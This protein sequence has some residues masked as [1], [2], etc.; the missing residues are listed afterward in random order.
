MKQK[1]LIVDDKPG[2]LLALEK[3]LEALDAVIVR[4]GSGE[5]AL[6]ACL[7]DEF[8]LAILDVQMPGMDG[9]ELARYLRGDSH[10][11]MLPIIFLSAVFSDEA[12]V[13][14]GY[15][16]G[17]VDFLTK[18]FRAEHLLGKARFFLEFDRQRAEL[19]ESKKALED[20]LKAQRE[21]SE[22]LAR[23]I[24]ARR[25]AQ[26]E[27]QLA[28]EAAEAANQAKGIFLA[29]MSHELRTPMNG[30]VGMLQLLASAGL[31]P[32][33]REYVDIAKSSALSLLRILSDI[34]DLS[35]IEAGK[36]E[37]REEPF[38]P[39]ELVSGVAQ[40]LHVEARGKGLALS[41]R[42]EAALPGCVSGDS[43][44]V[45]QVLINLAG[46]AIKFTTSGSVLIEAGYQESPGGKGTLLF[47][48]TDTGVGI[49]GDKLDDIFEPFTQVDGSYSRR[50][51]GAGL[52]LGIVKRIVDAMGG[53]IVVW[54]EE[55]K[56]TAMEVALPLA[57]LPGRCRVSD[58][59]AEGTGQGPLG[60]KVLV[61]E[62]DVIN[63]LAT[64]KFLEM[65]GCTARAV[66]DGDQVVP[67]LAQENFD[68]VLMDVSMARMDGP[69]AAR[70][71][72]RAGNAVPR[73]DIPIVA[74]TAHAMKGDRERYL[75][76]GMDD[77]I[78]KPVLIGQLRA[79]L[80]RVMSASR[81]A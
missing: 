24:E 12:H 42:F 5:A 33:Q 10:T 74:M 9:Y 25:Q 38:D 67:A 61:A 75:S 43:S 27:Q 11:R 2:N 18:P 6:K 55:G 1:I 26:E 28:M 16:A 47:S 40:A 48:V 3:V 46:N 56:G 8:A 35:R 14:M 19:A 45:R 66:E 31:P 57:T 20:L 60:Y 78:T 69:E 29:N 80:E 37:L 21:T 34:L 76:M 53:H 77:Y 73:T 30:V 44:R 68:L 65:L 59:H 17:A 13:D 58:Q 64:L 81:P 49:P 39:A 52:G 62:D 22:N 7:R 79:T 32:Q 71:V 72:R 70:E 41:Q 15:L 51:G 54:S 4:A 36:L 63:R 23:E 50:R